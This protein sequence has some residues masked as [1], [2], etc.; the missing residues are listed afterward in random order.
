MRNRFSFYYPRLH[1]A[2]KF[3]ALPLSLLLNGCT[4][5]SPVQVAAVAPSVVVTP[6][7]KSDA[8]RELHLSGSLSAERSMA[9]S[10]ATV[11]IVQQVMVQEGQAVKRG[12]VLAT[13]EKRGFQ[14]ALGIAEVKAKQAE[15]AYRRL[16]PIYNNKNLAEVKM[17]EVETGREQARLAVSA[18]NVNEVSD[19][20]TSGLVP[21]SDLLEAQ[22]LRQQSSDRRIDAC[23]DYWLKR[24]AFLRSVAADDK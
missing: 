10:F 8:A 19:Q 20:Q 1:R 16:L 7:V 17:V 22:A 4:Q 3:A 13:V 21:F 24:Y 12:Q 23:V 18:L 9:L 2:I 6:V 14:D 15:D 5:P 11:G